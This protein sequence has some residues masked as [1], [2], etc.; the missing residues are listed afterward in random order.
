MNRMRDGHSGHTYNL[1][2]KKFNEYVQERERECV[3]LTRYFQLPRCVETLLRVEN[4]ADYDEKNIR[5]FL[6]KNTEQNVTSFTI[7]PN[8]RE[9]IYRQSNRASHLRHTSVTGKARRVTG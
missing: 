4:K 7:P 2:V 9:R 1:C 5:N 6:L 8:I 3:S